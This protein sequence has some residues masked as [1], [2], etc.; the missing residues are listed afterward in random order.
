MQL[1]RAA[2]LQESLIDTPSTRYMVNVL[3]I[4]LEGVDLYA[5]LINS[6]TS[7]DAL[8]FYRPDRLKCGIRAR[9]ASLG[10]ALALTS[11]LRWYIQRYVGEILF[12]PEEGIFC[13]SSLAQQIYRRDVK[14]MP[15][16]RY[17]CLYRISSHLVEIIWMDAGTVPQAYADQFEPDDTVLEVWCTEEEHRAGV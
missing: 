10:S 6:E 14:P 8:R 11:E 16:W 9:T 3:L 2:L 7:R 4:Q 5:T 1:P 15:P 12:E 17:R 13:S